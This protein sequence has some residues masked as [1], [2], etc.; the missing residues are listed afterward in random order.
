MTLLMVASSASLGAASIVIMNADG[1]GEGFND[2]TP[3]APV[4][5]NAG[6]TLGQQRLN[7]FSA[8]AAYWANR[9]TSPVQIVVLARMDPLFCN[10]TSAVL[11]SAGPVDF[12]RDFGSAPRPATWF[13]VSLA[14]ALEG[15]DLAGTDADVSAQ[16]NSSLNGSPSCL[17]GKS[18]SY[19][20]GAA[21]P[22]GTLPFYETVRHEIT[23]GLGFGTLVNTTSGA[24][25]LG[26]DDIFMTL[27]EDHSTGKSWPQMS[28]AERA[29][30][31]HDPG[32]LHWTGSL[33]QAA[34]T[35]LLAGRHPSGHLQMYSP[36][37]VSPGS[38]VSH[39]DTAITP[40][41]MMEPFATANPTDIVTTGL[42]RDLGWAVQ[43]AG[44]C[45]R[46]A[47]TAC[48]GS[49]RFEVGVTFQ[50]ATTSGSAQVMS[51]G[52][53]RAETD[54]SAFFWFFGANNFEMGLKLLDACALNGKRWVFVSGLTDQGWTVTVR[55][56]QT[57]AVKI[58]SNAVGHLS[59]TF[60]DT[61][62]FSCP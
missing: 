10:A 25:A 24:R 61:V 38:S 33:A 54:E 20:V 22:A 37:V 58:Y 36:L 34:G 49:D 23:H 5:G 41:E 62:A 60:A 31:A 40:D 2:A 39:W 46:D 15:A 14:N 21:A 45:V 50:T 4:T 11:G 13:A 59:T 17:G 28:D 42:L 3:A 52:G 57:G 35:G 29:N 18:W 6:T 16:F 27:L 48:L 30:S 44:G 56:T 43:Q 19:V 1:A 9:L 8:A 7:A 51:F 26:F 32:D 55:D 47:D 12:V 53:Q